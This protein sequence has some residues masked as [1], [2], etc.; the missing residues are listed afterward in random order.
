MDDVASDNMDSSQTA[1]VDNVDSVES[2]GVNSNLL[3]QQLI[4]ATTNLKTSMDNFGVKAN[5]TTSHYS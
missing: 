2:Y 1:V 5:E 4:I 3:L